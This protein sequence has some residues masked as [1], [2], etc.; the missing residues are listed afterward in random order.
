MAVNTPRLVGAVLAFRRARERG[1]EL[2]VGLAAAGVVSVLPRPRPISGSWA[3]PSSVMAIRS[4]STTSGELWTHTL[5]RGSR[6]PHCARN[7]DVHVL[8]HLPRHLGQQVRSKSARDPRPQHCLDQ[9]RHHSGAAGRDPTWSSPV[10]AMLALTFL[11]Q[12]PPSARN[13][14][15]RTAHQNV[16]QPL[17]PNRSPRSLLHRS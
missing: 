10:R 11:F 2:A 7:E 6:A 9:R 14:L 13:C 5:P 15:I 12:Q 17:R 8:Q 1:L 16:L 4:R 3:C